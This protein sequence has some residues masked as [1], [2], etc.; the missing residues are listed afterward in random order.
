MGF[1]GWLVWVLVCVVGCLVCVFVLGDEVV[2]APFFYL[3][4]LVVVGVVGIGV[5][6]VFFKLCPSM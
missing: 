1:E 3:G 5:L 2:G 4:A 6:D